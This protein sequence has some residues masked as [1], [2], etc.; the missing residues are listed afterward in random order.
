MSDTSKKSNYKKSVLRTLLA[1]TTS[2]FASTVLQRISTFIVYILIGRSFGVFEFGQMSLALTLFFIFQI[3]STAGLQLLLIREI[4]GDKAKT[5]YYLFHGGIIVTVLAIIS[6]LLVSIFAVSMNYSRSTLIVI[7]LVSLGI[8]PYSLSVICDSVIQAWEKMHLMT[9]SYGVANVLKIAAVIILIKNQYNINYIAIALVIAHLF[10]L[11]IKFNLLS[12]NIVISKVSL[13]LFSC[14]NIIKST[15]IFWGIQG[16]IAIYTSLNIILLSKLVGETE[17][18]MYSAAS[19]LL[20]PIGLVMESTIL[21]TYPILCRRFNSDFDNIKHIQEK[22][23]QLLLS[24]I[25]PVGVALYFASDWLLILVY[26]KA[27]FLRAAAALRLLIVAMLMRVFTRVLGQF[28]L[29][30][31]KEKITLRILVINLIINIILGTILISN[32]KLSGAVYTTVFVT[33]ISLGQH[34]FAI[35]NIGIKFNYYNV[36]RNPVLAGVTMIFFLFNAS[37]LNPLISASFGVIIYFFVYL[38]LMIIESG[39]LKKFII[40]YQYFLSNF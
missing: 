6:I 22:L 34:I 24:F 20:V 40:K 10:E 32:F 25:L 15:M 17:V 2:M 18:G 37:F 27:D 26:E 19:Q 9:I 12:R 35:R 31:L 30:G 28:L 11:I 8:L 39:G 7:I 5:S 14:V 29:S 1:N 16:T 13:N 4:A 33:A 38:S 36:I 3:F 23:L 21:S